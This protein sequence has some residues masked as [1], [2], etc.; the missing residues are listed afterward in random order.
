M[1]GLSCRVVA[2][3]LADTKVSTV[4][5]MHGVG[6]AVTDVVGDAVDEVGVG[7]AEVVGDAVD[8]VGVGAAEV[9]GDAV[10]EV[11]VGAAE[12][13][14]D[15]VDEVGVGAAEVVGDAADVGNPAVHPVGDW[16]AEALGA[17][18]WVAEPLGS[19]GSGGDPSG[20]GIVTGAICPLFSVPWLSFPALVGQAGPA[21]EAHDSFGVRGPAVLVPWKKTKAA[22]LTKMRIAHTRSH[23]GPRFQTLLRLLV[24]S[25]DILHLIRQSGRDRHGLAPRAGERK[26]R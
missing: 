25:A 11:G 12:V 5:E 23:V 24:L 7:A 16:V 9:V 21:A 10:D 13:V 20:A 19:G 15:A 3:D 26:E 6:E 1:I 4:T 8:E 2:P 18:A 22:P 17:G 14:G